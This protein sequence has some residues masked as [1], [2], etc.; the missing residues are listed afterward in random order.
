M[1]TQI[2]YNII[3]KDIE[4]YEGIYSISNN[5]IVKS[6]YKGKERLLKQT[7]DKDGYCFVGLFKNK[8]NKMSRVHRL[9][10]QAFIPNPNKLPEINHIDEN[11]Q[12]NNVDNL[13]WC[14]H[15]YN[16]TY[17]LATPISQYSK[18][19]K[20]ITNWESI[21]KA[22]RTLEIDSGA[23]AHCCNKD[24]Y[25]KTFKG[26]IWRFKDDFCDL[27][28]LINGGS[29][30]VA[31]YNLDGKLIKIWNSQTEASIFLNKKTPSNINKCCIGSTK[32][33]Y[34]YIWQTVENQKEN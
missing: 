13:E 18:D 20:L 26:F 4:N 31:Q 9:V 1:E 10:A 25:A 19:G 27:E 22:S 8:K 11:K 21:I 7:R 3:W 16:S 17:S 33:A 28:S 6:F 34:G 29:K 24:K 12:N 30:K 23:I 5:G 2:L 14:T 15:K 32:T